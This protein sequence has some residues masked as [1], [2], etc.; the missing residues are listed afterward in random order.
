MDIF[1]LVTYAL[2]YFT[3]KSCLS[4]ELNISGEEYYLFHTAI[5]R[6]KLLMWTPRLCCSLARLP[7]S[8]VHRTFFQFFW[9]SSRH[10]FFFDSPE[11]P[12]SSIS[13]YLLT[14]ISRCSSVKRQFCRMGV[15]L[16]LPESTSACLGCCKDS[17]F[18]ES[19]AWESEQS[20]FC[21]SWNSAGADF[22]P[23]V[24]ACVMVQASLD[25]IRISPIDI[26]NAMMLKNYLGRESSRS[27]QGKRLLMRG[28]ENMRLCKAV[29]LA[30]I[31]QGWKDRK[32]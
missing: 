18:K 19:S 17:D 5:A 2:V 12:W 29:K 11:L 28:S 6:F 8:V 20:W 24:N 25:N 9:I 23:D 27:R 13:M 22:L 4:N 21:T 10:F 1:Y 31:G 26:W 16:L 3:G 14:S 15:T 32:V 7:P 30:N